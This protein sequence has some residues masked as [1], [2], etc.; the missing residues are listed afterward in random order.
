MPVYEIIKSTISK[1]KV[2]FKNFSSL[3]IL[4]IANYIFPLITFPYLVRVLGPDGFGLV[5]FATAFVNYFN[6]I[7]DYGFNLSATRE[8]SI[9]RNDKE[10]INRIYNSVLTVKL[11]LFLF[12]TI[13]FLLIVFAFPKFNQ[14]YEIYLASFISVF[15]MTL[16]PTW[17]F[18]GIERM[19]FIT[20]INVAIKAI[21]VVSIFLLVH[22]PSDI[23]LL[24]ILNSISAILIGIIGVISIPVFFRLKFKFAN[25]GEI[26]D[27]IK[28]GWLFFISN[29]SISL[30]T[31][32]AT[33]I[34]GLFANNTIVGYF[35]AADK[36][37][38]AV[39]N[40][41]AIAGR[42]VFPHLSKEFKRSKKAA[43]KFLKKYT[44]VTGIITFS[45]C[46]VLFLSAEQVVLI[47]LGKNYYQSILILKIISFLPFIILLSNIGGIQIMINL[48]YE[49]EYFLVYLVTSIISLLLSFI[50]VPFYF[51]IGTSITVI[52]TELLVTI[53]II[54]ILIYKNSLRYKKL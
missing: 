1:N 2:L 37:R 54:G 29:I 3:S 6:V 51:E 36:I 43:F 52:L 19:G 41:T 35:S 25:I 7:T 50:L 4:Q 23:L 17:F 10:E 24:V 42:T 21:W 48:N 45:I 22:N 27:Q 53:L 8:I 5:A 39:Q 40:L 18:Q 44:L 47:I 12:S 11:I 49:Y 34:L 9:S 16:F 26:I 13:V 14:D 46:T 33:F 31:I 15:G 32:S 20:G 28:K 38:L 30:Y